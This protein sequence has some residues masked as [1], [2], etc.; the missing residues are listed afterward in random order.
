MLDFFE[1][2]WGS[3]LTVISSMVLGYFLGALG[4]FAGIII[5]TAYVGYLVNIDMVNGA[6]HGSIVAVLAGALSFIIMLG[7]WGLGIGPSSTIMEFGVMGIVI[8]LLINLIVG[9]GGGAIGS[10]INQ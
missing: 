8:G 4:S 2:I 3:I 10:I 6:V 5:F 1:I 7:M 9:A